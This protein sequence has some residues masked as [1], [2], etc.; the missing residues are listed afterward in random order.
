M[1]DVVAGVLVLLLPQVAILLYPPRRRRLRA[2][3]I[4]RYAFTCMFENIE[5]A[6]D[7]HF[8]RMESD[9]GKESKIDHGSNS[10]L[11]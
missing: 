9:D 1:V 5:I 11:L 3:F 4:R 2:F 7:A 6:N 8:P 10:L